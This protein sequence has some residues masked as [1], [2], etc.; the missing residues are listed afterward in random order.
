MYFIIISVLVPV[1]A[2]L[3]LQGNYTYEKKLSLHFELFIGKETHF[4]Y[5]FVIIVIMTYIAQVFI[6]SLGISY[7]FTVAFVTA[8]FRFLGFKLKQ[9]LILSQTQDFLEEDDEIFKNISQ[10]VRLHQYCIHFFDSLNKLTSPVLVLG[11]LNVII[12]CSISG[13]LMVMKYKEDINFVL[14]MS[15]AYILCAEF[16]LVV[17][18]PSQMIS[19]ASSDI[20]E[21]CYSTDWYKYSIKTRKMIQLIMMRSIRSSCIKI[22]P[23]KYLNYATSRQIIQLS[24]SYFVSLL[25]IYDF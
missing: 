24:L 6:S 12:G 13:C 16:L 2:N 3:I 23:S 8:K 7:I 11:I 21:D 1:T 14:K 19:D 18:F 22:G 15:F 4:Y 9:I 10:L 20:F 5:Y 17:S 25:S